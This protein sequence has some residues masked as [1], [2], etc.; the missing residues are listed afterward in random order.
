[1][2][3]DSSK[4]G[5]NLVLFVV[6]AAQLLLLL[7]V[8]QVFLIEQTYGLTKLLPIV[9][10]G[11]VVH[12][13][14][15]AKWRGAFF[16]ALFPISAIVLLGPVAAGALL[17]LALGLFLICH[18]PVAL[19]WRVVILAAVGVGMAALRVGIVETHLPDVQS[20]LQT[21]TLPILASMFMFRTVI[22]LYDLRNEKRAVSIWQ[23]LSYF[24]LF[25]NVCF[26]LFP[27][28]DYQTFKRTYYDR[29]DA[30]IYQKGIDWILRGITHL[31][32]Y[33]I[34][35]HYFVPD[36]LTI[37]DVAG[38]AQYALSSFLLYLR[39]SGL[40]HLIIGILCL[41]GYNLPETHHRYYLSESFTDFWRRINIY[42]KDFMVKL[43]YFPLFMSLKRWGVTT[44]MI[45]ATLITFF[46]TW[47]LHS[48]Q[49]FWLRGTF[50][51]HPQDM[52]FWGILAILVTGNSLYEEKFGRRRGSLKSVTEFS[53]REATIRSVKTVSIFVIICLL[54]SFWT[55]TSIDQWLTVMSVVGTATMT[56]IVVTVLVLIGATGV[57]IL[58]QMPLAQ[59]RLSI[60]RPVS[61][62]QRA[63]KAGAAAAV[64]LVIANPAFDDRI[65]PQIAGLISTITGDQLN[66]RDQQQLVKGYYEELLGAESSGSMAW[67]VRLEQP[68]DWTWNGQPSSKFRADAQDIR[69]DLLLPSIS[70]V[71]KGQ[72]FRTNTWG[73][74]D[75]EYPLDKPDGTL[76]IAML[77]SSHTVGAGV[78]VEDTFPAI[79]ERYLNQINDG[80]TYERIEILNFANAGD[81]I[82]R[83]F[84]RFRIEALRF[85]PDIVVDMSITNE[86]HLAARNL[87]ASVK[88][89]IRDIDPYL[90]E[91]VARAGVTSG[92]SSE[93]VERRLGPFTDEL[94]AWAYTSLAETAR[95]HDIVPIV[96]LLP[97]I[98]DTDSAYNDEWRDLSEI[99]RKAAFTAINLGDAYGPLNERNQYKLAPWDWHPNAAGHT[100]IARHLV[101]QLAN[102]DPLS[103]IVRE[104]E[105]PYT[106]ARTD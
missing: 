69:G 5:T 25:P 20:Y 44:A 89:R 7:A 83:R 53:A 30:Q 73:M 41:F 9:F 78:K 90:A 105:S 17:G 16:V 96:V 6:Q 67:S 65:N 36:P 48:Y 42:W 85:D 43:F 81:S 1:M 93:E 47:L 100:L 38:A 12:A 71:N 51:L 19:W 39:V 64:L 28:I 21:Q 61:I 52:I 98:G 10:A 72:V 58:V 99:W 68:D 86:Q 3:P 37:Q 70:A 87:R 35:Y 34:V 8:A 62:R 26:P 77:G 94:V 101:Q 57:G 92:M 104:S 75:D 50:P 11:F 27:V 59:A 15:P 80:T 24:F 76:R 60:A 18:I 82:L 45:A 106:G 88:G 29:P 91:M 49:W 4:S 74:R 22:Y 79:V 103:A 33:R 46:I 31:L 2:V 54:W 13:W 97:L 55:S 84:A 40:F 95:A 102:V 32:L 56:E 23:R 66:D 63:I 14:L